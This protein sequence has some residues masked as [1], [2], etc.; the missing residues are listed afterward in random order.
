MQIN[1]SSLIFCLIN[2]LSCRCILIKCRIMYNLMTV[3]FL[4]K[5]QKAM[6]WAKPFIK[7]WS[8]SPCINNDGNDWSDA[9]FQGML[10]LSYQIYVN[11]T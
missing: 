10:V 3:Y 8:Y 5:C 4:P 7:T 2:Q 6:V 9:F 1:V 11:Q